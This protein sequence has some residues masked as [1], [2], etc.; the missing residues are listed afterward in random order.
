VA[1]ERRTEA[2][3][4]SP[5]SYSTPTVAKIDGRMQLIVLGAMS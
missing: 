4:E 5:D 2:I 3:R 1:H